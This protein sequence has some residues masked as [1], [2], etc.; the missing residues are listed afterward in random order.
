MPDG[1]KI[2]YA[3]DLD[4]TLAYFPHG[5][6]SLVD[7]ICSFGIERE[8]AKRLLDDVSNSHEGFSHRTIAAAV[9][10]A[11]PDLD[12][13]A[14]QD[15]IYYWLADGGIVLYPETKRVW[16]AAHVSGNTIAVITAGNPEWQHEKIKLLN[17]QPLHVFVTP[18]PVGK[19]AAI[20]SLQ[21]LVRGT[22]HYVDDRAHELDRIRD[23]CGSD[24]VRLFHIVRA[25]SI[26]GGAS[27]RHPHKRIA[28]LDEMLGP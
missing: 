6:S 7:V 28:S 1:Q 9:S 18:P 24:A 8:A 13:A 21:D 14:F 22:I 12:R 3:F 5:L 23:S 26:D 19:A 11:Y 25:D 16:D 17:L 27:A 2:C 20:T 10:A 4:N 15:T